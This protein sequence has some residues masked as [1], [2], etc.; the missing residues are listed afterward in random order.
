VVAGAPPQS[1]KSGAGGIF[2]KK[3]FGKGMMRLGQVPLAGNRTRT[4]IFH[5]DKAPKKEELNAYKDVLER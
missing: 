1:G 3:D 5:V 2:W 4:V